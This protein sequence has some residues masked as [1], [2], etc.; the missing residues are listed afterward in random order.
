MMSLVRTAPKAYFSTK[1]ICCPL[2]SCSSN[3]TVAHDRGY[4]K[5]NQIASSS[6]S[7]C[8]EG[9]VRI[10]S[11]VFFGLGKWRTEGEGF[12]Y[13]LDCSLEVESYFWDSRVA[14]S[15]V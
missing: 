8:N 11:M 14:S 5:Y 2:P 4:P 6:I 12:P 7:T 10:F 3:G 13:P 9:T 1:K 15:T